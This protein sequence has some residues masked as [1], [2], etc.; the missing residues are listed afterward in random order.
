MQVFYC[1][2]FEL[3]LPDGHRFPITKYRATRELVQSRLGESVSLRAAPAASDEQLQRVHDASYLNSVSQGTLSE[4]DQKRIGF[5]WSRKMLQRSLRSTGATV[6]TSLAALDDSIAVH[7]SGGTHHAFADQGQGFCVFNDVAVAAQ[8]LLTRPSIRRI[9]VVD[10]DVHQ[11][12]GTASI[13]SGNP[14]VF[15]FSMHGDRNYPFRKTNGDLDIGLPDGTTDEQYLSELQL[16]FDSGLPLSE[17]DFAFYVA[18]ADPFHGDRMGRI[19]MTKEGLRQRDRYVLNEL[20][21]RSIPTAVVMGGG[22][23]E[24]A[25]VAE[26]H[27]N[28]V[29]E[30]FDCFTADKDA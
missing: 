8:E 10:L 15:T 12:N 22:Y 19:K 4:L 9:L 7:L 17:T 29:Q 25:D 6:A 18:G 23:A 11:G 27:F 28:T 26:I 16:V 20:R 30:A 1:D 21:Q 13:F 3:P 5:P 14:H 2:H 24:V